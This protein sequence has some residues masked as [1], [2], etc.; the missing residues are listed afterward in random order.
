[1]TNVHVC[2]LFDGGEWY[3]CAS[4]NINHCPIWLAYVGGPSF[5]QV[6]NVKELPKDP[7]N[8]LSYSSSTKEYDVSAYL[9]KPDIPLRRVTH[10]TVHALLTLG[11]D[12]QETAMEKQSH[13]VLHPR[14]QCSPTA[15]KRLIILPRKQCQKGTK[16]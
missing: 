3:L 2:V 6:T 13:R 16:S 10:S 5:V 1:M 14:K 12:L 15:Q 7:V 9:Q 4:S 11:S 8:V